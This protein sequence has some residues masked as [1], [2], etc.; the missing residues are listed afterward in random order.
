MNNVYKLSFWG[1]GVGEIWELGRFGTR[2][3][4]GCEVIIEKMVKLSE[5]EVTE[6]ETSSE[7]SSESINEETPQNECIVIPKY[8]QP[9]FECCRE[10]DEGKID[11]SEFFARSLIRTGE[12]M[13]NV[14]KRKESEVSE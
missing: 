10:Y 3:K 6:E 8:M 14:K 2:H 4:R 13:Q 12:F 5:E 9:L 7:E 1:E 11:S